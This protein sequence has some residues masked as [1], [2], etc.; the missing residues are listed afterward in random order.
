MLLVLLITVAGCGHS[1]KRAGGPGALAGAPVPQ[2]P[3]FLSGPM[4][5]LFTNASGFR[6]HVV[7]DSGPVAQGGEVVTG[8]LMGR[9]SRL[10]FASSLSGAVGKHSPEASAAFIWDVNGNHGYLLN[11]PLQ[12]Y[13]VVS[14]G[15]QFTNVSVGRGLGAA[16]PEKV[17]GHPCQPTEV[18]VTASDGTATV[19]SAWRATDL[20]G[21]PLRITAVAN[22]RPLTLTLS[23]VRL[24]AV[25]DDLFL[26][27][28][29]FTK[30][31]SAEALANELGARQQNLKRHPVYQTEESE[32]GSSREYRAPARPQ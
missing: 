22:G 32:P 16:A 29:G 31:D 28:N 20:K 7:L 24:E 15:Q 17:A 14:S 25:P 13:A 10:V 23:K 6:A 1:D 12:A 30:Y 19:L 27:P 26:P 8:E 9:G 11:E 5:L 3:A 18:T 21:L 4:S 2:P